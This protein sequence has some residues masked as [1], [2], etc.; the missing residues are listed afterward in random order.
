MVSSPL[1]TYRVYCFDG[2]RHDLRG[3]LIEASSDEA[4]IAAAE[5]AGFGTRAEIWEGNRLVA[6]L[7]KRESA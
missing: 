4:A 1:V 6:E 2:V 5:A 3:D 7:S